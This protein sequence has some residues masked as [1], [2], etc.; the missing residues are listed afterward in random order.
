M[1]ILKYCSTRGQDNLIDFPQHRI[2][3]S[4]L[5]LFKLTLN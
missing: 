4:R 1:L 2:Q 3:Y 5:K